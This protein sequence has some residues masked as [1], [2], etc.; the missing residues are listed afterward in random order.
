VICQLYAQAALNMGNNCRYS[1]SKK[2][3]EPHGRPGRFG[4][5][6]V[7]VFLA[8]LNDLK[9]MLISLCLDTIFEI[10]RFVFK[11]D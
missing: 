11:I 9:C 10:S 6:F 8:T 3:C 2:H 4:G 1:M 5:K 7:G